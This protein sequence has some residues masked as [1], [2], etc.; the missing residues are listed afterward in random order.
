MPLPLAKR[1]AHA[2]RSPVTIAADGA[3]M[4][5][6]AGSSTAP[7][8]H[9]VG[10]S[11]LP[12]A[13]LPLA[14]SPTPAGQGPLALER[15]EAKHFFEA[16]HTLGMVKAIRLRAGVIGKDD[17]Q[18]EADFLEAAGVN[19]RQGPVVGGVKQA[20]PGNP[21]WTPRGGSQ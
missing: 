16:C 11:S 10:G 7:G 8:R 6:T 9:T 13:D 21:F 19:Q 18:L 4:P 1:R 12:P 2:L 17:P 15:E 20:R 3:A 5:C 14:G